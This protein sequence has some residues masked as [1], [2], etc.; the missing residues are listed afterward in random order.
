MREILRK[1]NSFIFN[2]H[3]SEEARD[4]YQAS[5][6][7]NANPS[8][9]FTIRLTAQERELVERFAKLYNDYLDLPVQ[10]PHDQM[11]F[12]EALHRIQHLILYRAGWRQ[13]QPAP[14]DDCPPAPNKR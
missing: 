1:L 9:R 4:H 10:H 12:T 8:D 5:M 13:I 14:E 6:M 11:E 3:S 7:G 2:V